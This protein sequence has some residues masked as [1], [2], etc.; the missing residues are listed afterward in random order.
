MS[1][2]KAA[3]SCLTNPEFW[4]L[5]GTSFPPLNVLW[6]AGF[7]LIAWLRKQPTAGLRICCLNVQITYTLLL[8]V[9]FVLGMTFERLSVTKGMFV[10]GSQASLILGIV[11]G[12]TGAFAALLLVFFNTRNFAQSILGHRRSS[13]PRLRFFPEKSG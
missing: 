10:P 3:R 4:V 8:A 7:A 11:L 12:L 5:T 2:T 9:P 1:F 6:A 13:I